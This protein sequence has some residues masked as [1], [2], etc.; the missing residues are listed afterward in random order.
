MT[1]TYGVQVLFEDTKK[2]TLHLVYSVSIA[3]N[4]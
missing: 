1:L 4:E 2:Y 3:G